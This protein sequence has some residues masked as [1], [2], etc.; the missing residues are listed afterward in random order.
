[1][2][3]F[4]FLVSEPGETIEAEC[5]LPDSGAILALRLRPTHAFLAEYDRTLVLR[6]A[7]G[8]EIA[9]DLLAD[10]GGYAR[11][12]L[13]AFRDGSYL[14]RGSFDA[15]RIEATNPAIAPVSRDIEDASEYVGAFDFDER[16]RWRFF[17]LAESRERDLEPKGG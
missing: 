4:G 7:D 14:L 17:A 2:V 11:T 12:H 6:L 13:Y 10:T 1:L 9:C 3:S 5:F 15:V 16:R 8:R